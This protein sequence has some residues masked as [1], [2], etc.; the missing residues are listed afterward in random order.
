MYK[1]RNHSFKKWEEYIVN[2]YYF[3]FFCCELK[4]NDHSSIDWRSQELKSRHSLRPFPTFSDLFNENVLFIKICL[5]YLVAPYLLK[6]INNS[7]VDKAEKY[8][9]LTMKILGGSS[10][11]NMIINH[12]K[13]TFYNK[14]RKHT[15]CHSLQIKQLK[16]YLKPFSCLVYH[17]HLTTI[18]YPL[19][20]F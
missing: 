18:Y 15:R 17:S 13:M 5:A 19:T 12:V 10:K 1:S 20:V 6:L 9:H 11:S 3:W 7:F 2:W 4:K 16:T 14:G 8:K